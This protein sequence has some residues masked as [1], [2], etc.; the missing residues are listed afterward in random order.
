MDSRRRPPAE[1]CDRSAST[2]SV[3]V[4]VVVVVLSVNDDDGD[5]DD[6]AWRQAHTLTLSSKRSSTHSFIH[7]TQFNF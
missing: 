1:A 2:V 5:D 6:A 3:L 7:L 4:V